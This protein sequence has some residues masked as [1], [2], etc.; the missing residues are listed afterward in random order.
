MLHPNGSMIAQR[1][2]TVMA[3]MLVIK[4]QEGVP[5][6]SARRVGMENRSAILTWMNVRWRSTTA[7][8]N[9]PTASTP[10]AASSVSAS[11]TTRPSRC[12]RTPNQLHLL[13]RSLLMLSRCILLLQGS[14]PLNLNRETIDSSR[15]LQPPHQLSPRGLHQ[16]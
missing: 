13:L 6:E 16:H 14:H 5:T 10:L 8:T 12:A 11:N 4:R 1:A 2:V 7:P 15:Q 9:N 3:E